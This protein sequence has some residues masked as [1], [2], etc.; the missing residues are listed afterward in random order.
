M[1]RST[2]NGCIHF[3]SEP[4]SNNY[5]RDRCMLDQQRPVMPEIATR[6]GKQCGPGRKMWSDGAHAGAGQ[7][8]TLNVFAQSV[9]VGSPYPPQPAPAPVMQS[10]NWWDA[11]IQR[12]WATHRHHVIT[13]AAS[14]H[15]E[16]KPD[17]GFYCRRGT[18]ACIWCLDDEYG[19]TGQYYIVVGLEP[20]N[21]PKC[22]L[23]IRNIM[24]GANVPN[25]LVAPG[26]IRT[27]ASP[28]AL[29]GTLGHVWTSGADVNCPRAG[30]T[31]DVLAAI[32]EDAWPHTYGGLYRNILNFSHLC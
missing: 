2:C 17:H 25:P 31:Y 9:G 16:A 12:M 13:P 5:T 23:A 8:A 10:S 24:Q 21:G 30:V 4:I 32:F 14:S 22:F 26:A 29:A 27:Y 28:G 6:S 11:V 15:D 19:L 20:A 3:R 1:T 18:G 7:L